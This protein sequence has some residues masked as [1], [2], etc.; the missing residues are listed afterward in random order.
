MDLDED[1]EEEKSNLLR[2]MDFR[3]NTR[4]QFVKHFEAFSFEP[5]DG[6]MMV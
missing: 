4:G 1:L 5:D 2:P 6:L 3:R